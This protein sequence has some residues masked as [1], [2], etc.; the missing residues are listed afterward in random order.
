MVH[1]ALLAHLC[2][3]EPWDSKNLEEPPDLPKS[4]N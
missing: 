4:L 3:N 2:E 1:E